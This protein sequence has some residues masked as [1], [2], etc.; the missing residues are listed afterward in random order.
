MG[1]SK[2]VELAT[3]SFKKQRDAALFF[4]AMLNRYR[5][6]E[7]VS[8]EDGLD[9]A[10]LGSNLLRVSQSRPGDPGGLG[11][12]FGNGRRRGSLTAA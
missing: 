6:G 2:P 7:R 5:P 11:R 4:K 12:F 8:D 3:R 9:V 10:A 1:R